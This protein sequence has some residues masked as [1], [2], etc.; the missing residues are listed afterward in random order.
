MA[1]LGKASLRLM[2]PSSE[3]SESFEIQRQRWHTARAR[4]RLEGV[5]RF[6]SAGSVRSHSLPRALAS[7]ALSQSRTRSPSITKIG[8]IGIPT[9]D[10]SWSKWSGIEP[11]AR[12]G[13][14]AQ[15]PT[16]LFAR[17]RTPTVR[18]VSIASSG[19]FDSAIPSESQWE[20][21]KLASEVNKAGE[22]EWHTD[23]ESAVP[24]PRLQ[25]NAAASQ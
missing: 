13:M 8:T 18:E 22:R 2:A 17:G 3:A 21:D 15:A 12:G 20:D 10:P 25:F 19:Q 1:K 5:V 24:S 6:S 7:S 4:D 14:R 23:T 16:P 9:R 11:A